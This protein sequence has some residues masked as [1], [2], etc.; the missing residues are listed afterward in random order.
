MLSRIFAVFRKDVKSLTV[1]PAAGIVLLVSSGIFN[2]FFFLLVDQEGEATLRDIFK[3]MEFMLVFIMPLLTMKMFAE[4]RSEGTFELLMTSPVSDLALVLGKFSAVFFFYTGMLLLTLP[5]YFILEIYSEPDRVAILSGYLGLW[6]EGALFIAIG[7]AMSA[8][9]RSQV[10]AAITAYVIL[11][12]SYFS[13]GVLKFVSGAAAE[14]VRYSGVWSH[15]ENLQI[16]IVQSTDMIYFASLI[17]FF[18]GLTRLALAR[19]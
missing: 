8:L 19:R 15:A 1:S 13:M 6:M 3:V 10:I 2:A 5:Y 11:F 18:F 4:E 17:V 16:G 12:L 7:M 9:T 14:V